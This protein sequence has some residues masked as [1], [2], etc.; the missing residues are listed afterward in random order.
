MELNVPIYFIIIVYPVIN[1]IQKATRNNS[2]VLCDVNGTEG[3]GMLS[4]LRIYSLLLQLLLGTQ[5]V[6]FSADNMLTY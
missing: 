5:Y 3:F 4:G 6:P 2:F 1:A